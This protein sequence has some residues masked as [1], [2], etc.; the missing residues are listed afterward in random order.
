MPANAH[1]APVIPSE[2]E[3][4]LAKETK[5]I[6]AKGL[7]LTLPLD[8]RAMNYAKQPTI[9]IPASA[10]RLLIQI[11]DEMSRGNA[12]KMIPVHAELTTQEA[13]DL[14]NISRPSL[15]QLLNEGKIEFRKVGTHRRIRLE[16]VVG[17]KRQMDAD[18]KAAL[19][20]LS[21]YDQELG[22]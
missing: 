15:I 4:T 1:L 2:A 14:L 22:L 21:A 19:A 10:A 16:N 7:S 3:A 9:K 12:V 6:L 18:R 13:A 11:L 20:E 5:Q 17:Y 8:L